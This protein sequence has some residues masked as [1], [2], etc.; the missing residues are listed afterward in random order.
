M[1]FNG[2]SATRR[3]DKSRLPFVRTTDA[4]GI[5]G[6]SFMLGFECKGLSGCED[7]SNLEQLSVQCTATKTIIFN[8]NF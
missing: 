1:H 8:L 3:L 5:L 6:S 4:L 7:F 2:E